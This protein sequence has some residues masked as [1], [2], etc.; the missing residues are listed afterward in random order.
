MKHQVSQKGKF[1]EMFLRR[2]YIHQFIKNDL[3]FG[4]QPKWNVTLFL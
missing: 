1:R 4:P 3:N 2:I